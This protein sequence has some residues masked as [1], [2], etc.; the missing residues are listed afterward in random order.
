[1]L[2]HGPAGIGKTL[3]VATLLHKTRQRLG[4]EFTVITLTPADLVSSKDQGKTLLEA[5][6]QAITSGGPSIFWV[7]EIDYIAK[8]KNLFY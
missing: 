6:E 7:E 8:T 2:V 1:M 3:A 4:E 5:F